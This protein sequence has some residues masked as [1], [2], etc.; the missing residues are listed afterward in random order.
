MRILV[1]V[2]EV[3]DTYGSRRLHAGTG[4]LVRS[5][6]PVLD[7]ISERALEVA[8]DHADH[9]PGTEVVAVCLGPAGA[10]TSVRKALAM[11]ADSAIH[12][13]DDDLVGADAVLTATVLAAA[14]RREAFDLVITGNASTDGGGG[15]L[16]VM[17]SE[18][19]DVP[20][21]TLLTSVEIA[22]GTLRGTRVADGVR[23]TVTASLPAVASITE[24]FPDPRFP[25]FKGT[26]AAKKKPLEQLALADLGITVDPATT[27]YAIMTAVAARPPRAAGTKI[28]DTGDAGRQLAAFLRSANLASRTP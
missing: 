22:D 25:S 9:H 15:V 12:V 6:D 19:L 26:M 7:E 23:M 27:P 8:L 20:A 14:I 13:V 24:A 16:P 4:L 11:G 28:T 5:A 3:P 10:V 17:L 1:L 18:L 21:A 2:K